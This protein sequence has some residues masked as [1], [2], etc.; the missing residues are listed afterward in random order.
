MEAPA[1]CSY[2]SLFYNSGAGLLMWAAED[3]ELLI[4]CSD[5]LICSSLVVPLGAWI[6]RGSRTAWVQSFTQPPPS[7]PLCVIKQHPVTLLCSTGRL[8]CLSFP[9]INSWAA[10]LR[11]LNQSQTVTTPLVLSGHKYLIYFV[12]G[13][14]HISTKWMVYY[15]QGQVLLNMS[16]LI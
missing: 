15:S 1:L 9:P 8:T 6:L 16:F 5:N 7:A 14:R 13:A 11:R 10:P 4:W 2:F 3:R 12:T